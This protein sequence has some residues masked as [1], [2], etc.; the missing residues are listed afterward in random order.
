MNIIKLSFLFVAAVCFSQ[1]GNLKNPLQLTLPGEIYAV[2]DVEMSIYF[3]N[4]V[5]TKTPEKYRFEVNCKIGKVEQRRWRVTPKDSEVG[6]HQLT[7]KV[8]SHDGKRIASRSTTLNVVPKNTGAKRKIRLLIVGDS[9]THGTQYPNEIGRLLSLPENPEWQMLGTHKP[10][11]AGKGVA[12]EGY[13][14]WTWSRFNSYYESKPRKDGRKHHSPFVYS[15]G[16]GKPRLN[17]G[18]F[19]KEECGNKPPDFVII[20][21]GINDCFSAPA[22]NPSGI[23]TR[24]DAMFKQADILVTAFRKAAPQVE[25]GIC[26]TTP[27]NSR[28]AAFTANY[29]GR[30]PRWGWKQIQHRLVQRQLGKFAN[31][32]GNRI[33]IIPTQLDLDPIDGYPENNGVHP[34]AIG[35]KKIGTTIYAWLKWRFAKRG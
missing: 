20:M 14:G 9:L 24:I 8:S 28:E 3:D 26:L 21:L 35:Y 18:R 10:K 19:L 2:Q 11:S 17:I 29:R 1:N 25:I 5:L 30:Y 33:F 27:P 7:I 16:V 31:G 34:N 6:R 15:E 22:D 13:G 32:R 12:H 23:D 4:V